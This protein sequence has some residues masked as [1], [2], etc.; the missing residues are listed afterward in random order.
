MSK[1]S[2]KTVQRLQRLEG[3]ITKHL[4]QGLIPFWHTHARDAKHGG[5]LT[6]FNEQGE[7]QPMKEKYVNTQAR[8]V[9]WFSN[10]CRQQPNARGSAALARGGAEFLLKH[11]WDPKHGGW[12]WKTKPNGGRSDTGKIV[13]GE[14]K[15]CTLI[16]NAIEET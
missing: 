5:Y 9:W 15:R 4:T 14:V 12:Y 3:E 6:R 10:L 11:F 7:A 1:S 2:K 16:E 8:L 13:Y